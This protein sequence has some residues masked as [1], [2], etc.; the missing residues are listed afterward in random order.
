MTTTAPL[1]VLAMAEAGGRI[2]PLAVLSK[3]PPAGFTD[4]QK[5]H[6]SSAADEI[7]AWA[8]EYPKCNWAMLCGTPSDRVVLDYDCK[9]GNHGLD[10]LNSWINEHGSDWLQT[11]WV[12]TPSGALHQH[13]KLGSLHIGKDND[14]TL[15]SGVDVQGT[16]SYVVI[17]PSKLENGIYQFQPGN[18]LDCPLLFVPDWMAPSLEKIIPAAQPVPAATQETAS[19]K[20]PSGQ[21]KRHD[22]LIR[23]AGKLIHAG[24]DEAA[25]LQSMLWFNETQFQE[26]WP[27]SEIRRQ[28]RDMV[29]RYQATKEPILI[30]GQSR[31]EQE[32]EIKSKLITAPESLSSTPEK[33]EDLIDGLVPEG[34][35]VAMAAQLKTGKTTLLFDWI[36]SVTTGE[37]W[38]DREVKQG[39][40]IYLTEQHRTSFNAQLQYAGINSDRMGILYFYECFKYPWDAIANTMV[41][42]AKQR[43]AKLIVVDTFPKWA[44][45]EKDADPRSAQAM[46][47][48]GS[49]VSQGI[50]VVYVFHSTKNSEVEIQNAIAGTRAYGG[51]VDLI[52]H[53]KRPPGNDRAGNHR[54]LTTLGRFHHIP[55]HLALELVDNRY[56]IRGEGSAIELSK[57]IQEIKRYLPAAPGEAVTLANLMSLA[58][59]ISR[60]TAQRAIAK[61]G[62]SRIDGNRQA[63]DRFFLQ[64]ESVA[65]G[66]YKPIKGLRI[67]AAI[68]P[69]PPCSVDR[70]VGNKSLFTQQDDKQEQNQNPTP[71]ILLGQENFLA[72]KNNALAQCETDLKSD[73]WEDEVDD[74]QS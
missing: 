37:P 41:K 36:R 13:F 15:A 44:R 33:T 68:P 12:K 14:G 39:D 3:L 62:A 49:A 54:I 11:Q 58:G 45:I 70:A 74:D 28:A 69:V 16:G 60:R 73:G 23:H 35:A 42:M 48:I 5:D 4:W 72:S 53:L 43:N 17:P 64:Q 61:L 46:D 65:R 29:K 10:Q 7:N 57:A 20:I 8:Q 27:E 34:I 2:F 71:A 24:I 47:V 63:P 18:G 9:N 50:T 6:N 40:I 55:E 22:A 38:C 31:D 52:F 21:R 51:N 67:E 30:L 19:G 59:G 66:L 32:S 26:P 56:L 1:E 25:L